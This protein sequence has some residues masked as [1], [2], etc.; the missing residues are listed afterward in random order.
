MC[1]QMSV[2]I[3]SGLDG[4]ELQGWGEGRLVFI[5]I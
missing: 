4:S 5:K 2:Y 1:E 3:I